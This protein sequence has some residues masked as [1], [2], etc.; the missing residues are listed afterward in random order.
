M[1]ALH[2]G[3]GQE[4]REE[5]VEALVDATLRIRDRVVNHGFRRTPHMFFYHVNVG[6]PV[7]DDGSRYL[8]PIEDVV[9]AAHAGER[10]QRMRS[11]GTEIATDLIDQGRHQIDDPGKVTRATAQAVAGAMLQEKRRSSRNFGR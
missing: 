6:H 8:A 1:G 5:L 9:F 10:A 3:E 11:D 7:L 2:L 4:L